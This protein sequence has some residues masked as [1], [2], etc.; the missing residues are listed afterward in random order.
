M[1]KLNKKGFM[2]TETLVVATFIVTTLVF[3]YTQ[4][5]TINKSYTNG[6]KYNGSEELYALGNISSYLQSNGLNLIGPASIS[7]SSKY[8]EVSSC[9]DSYLS[10]TTYCKALMTSLNIKKVIITNQNL[11]E[12][13]GIMKNDNELSEEMKQFITSVK[14]DKN[15]TGYR[16]IAEFLNGTFATLNVA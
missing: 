15:K 6:F 4:V 5:R 1:K 9:R 7:T 8:I 14:Y 3:L 10:E 2:L 11:E 13:K 12:L 16:L